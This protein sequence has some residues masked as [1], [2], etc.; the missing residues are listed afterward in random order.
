MPNKKIT[1]I[2]GLFKPNPNQRN[3]SR[4]PDNPFIRPEV[5]GVCAGVCSP[6]TPPGCPP[7]PVYALDDPLVDAIIDFSSECL[8][9]IAKIQ[10]GRE[11][12]EREADMEEEREK[13]KI[14][15]QVDKIFNQHQFFL[16]KPCP[17]M[18]PYKSTLTHQ[19]HN[20]YLRAFVKTTIL[21]THIDDQEYQQYM[22]LHHK[23]YEE[24]SCF[25]QFSYQVSKLQLDTYNTIPDVI[26]QYMRQYYEARRQRVCDY[27]RHYV[28]EQQVPIRPQ[29]PSNKMQS[30]VFTHSGHLLSL[31]S[32]NNNNDIYL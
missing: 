6:P 7:T 18:I 26:T 16:K 30:L 8:E 3:N 5:L 11:E 23:V 14:D 13:K 24:Q 4:S 17:V 2:P 32:N 19:Q 27:K 12:R 29:D 15:T 31:V 9:N 20:A 22:S 28:Y 1:Y 21:H 25:N 10:R